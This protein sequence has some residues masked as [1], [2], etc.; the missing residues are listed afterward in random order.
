MWWQSCATPC[1]SLSPHDIFFFVAHQA[2]I[3]VC[4]CLCQH[5]IDYFCVWTSEPPRT[6]HPRLIITPTPV[7][8]GMRSCWR[9]IVSALITSRDSFFF[10]FCCFLIPFYM[11]VLLFLRLFFLLLFFIPPPPCQSSKDDI[12]SELAAALL[13]FHFGTLVRYF[14]SSSSKF[15][16]FYMLFLYC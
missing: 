12:W 1:Y 15:T 16:S 14:I 7:S 8:A 13:T 2:T 5:H 4:V 3:I 9:A 10:L 11:F 6:F